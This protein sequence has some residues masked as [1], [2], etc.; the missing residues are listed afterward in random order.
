M[1]RN[2]ARRALSYFNILLPVAEKDHN[3]LG[4]AVL[5]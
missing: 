3:T 5:E 2:S 1:Y 4:Y